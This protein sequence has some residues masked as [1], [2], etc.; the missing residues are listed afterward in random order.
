[1][2]FIISDTFQKALGKLNADEQAIVKQAAF[3]FQMNPKNPGFSFEDL[4]RARDKNMWSFRASSDLRI[5]V[6]RTNTSMTLT[7]DPNPSIYGDNVKFT[8]CGLPLDATGT[9]TLIF[10]PYAPAGGATTLNMSS[11]LHRHALRQVRTSSLW[12]LIQCLRVL[13]GT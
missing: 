12:A 7:S 11:R 4:Q 5:I 10:P 9:V 1:M 13:V 6:H 8:A 3:D 2:N